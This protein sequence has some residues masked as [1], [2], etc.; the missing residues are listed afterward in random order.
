MFVVFVAVFNIQNL[1]IVLLLAFILELNE[2]KIL[3]CLGNITEKM[4]LIFNE[5]LFA[6]Y[7][8]FFS[9]NNQQ[10]AWFL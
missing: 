10:Q 5:G 7:H 8:C 2:G 4:L 9:P 6:C 1:K 3:S